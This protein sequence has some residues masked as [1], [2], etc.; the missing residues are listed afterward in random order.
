LNTAKRFG[1][2]HSIAISRPDTT[3][4]ER[5]IEEFSSVDGVASLLA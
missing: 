5:R 2:A 4:A 1:I 3:K